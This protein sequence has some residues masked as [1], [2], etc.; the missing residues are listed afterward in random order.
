MK[1]ET[2]KKWAKIKSWALFRRYSSYVL[3]ALFLQKQQQQPRIKLFLPNRNSFRHL[4]HTPIT[5]WIGTTRARARTRVHCIFQFIMNLTLARTRIENICARV[6]YLFH[7]LCMCVVFF[8]V[9]TIRNYV[10]I[11]TSCISHLIVPSPFITIFSNCV[12]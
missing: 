11:H 5:K 4:T 8:R 1:I 10:G 6:V 12:Q 2:K 3:I 9:S 7:L